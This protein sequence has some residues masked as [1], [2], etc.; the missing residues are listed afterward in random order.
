MSWTPALLR[1]LSP[2]CMPVPPLRRPAETDTC[3]FRRFVKTGVPPFSRHG[4]LRAGAGR[5]ATLTYPP[6]AFTLKGVGPNRDDAPY[7]QTEQLTTPD[8]TG[9][10]ADALL[11]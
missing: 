2:A 11:A 8:G 6:I 9:D 10:P 4:L 1:I 5:V 3:R 7:N